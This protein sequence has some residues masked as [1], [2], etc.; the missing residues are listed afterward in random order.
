MNVY[1]VKYTL[2]K[3]LIVSDSHRNDELLYELVKEYPKMDLYLHAGDSQ[4]FAE[5][6]FP[7]DSC[8]GNCDS[9]PFM[10]K[11]FFRTEYGNISMKHFPH[12]NEEEKKDIRIF[13][14]GHTHRYAVY[15]EEDILFI[16]PGSISLA[17]DNSNGSFAIL[18]LEKEH[19]NVDVIDIFTKNILTSYQIL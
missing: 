2:M 19:I 14:Y 18:T 12:L 10:E 9:Y 13:I 16:N 17:R 1:K 6:V 7:F 4:S 15:E 8:L 5:G 3:I 11:R